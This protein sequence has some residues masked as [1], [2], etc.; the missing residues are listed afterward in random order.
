MIH[1]KLD[2][3]KKEKKKSLYREKNILELIGVLCIESV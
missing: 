1:K 3:V 2:E